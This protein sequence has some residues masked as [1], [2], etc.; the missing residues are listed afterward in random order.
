MQTGKR[1]AIEKTS[2]TAALRVYLAG[3]LFTI[4]ERRCNREL[5]RAIE[6]ELPGTLVLLP[7]DFKIDGRYNDQRAFGAI[8]KGCIDGIDSCHCMVAWLDGPDSDS[9]TCFEVGYAYAKGMPVIGVRTD[10]RL[11]QER[12]VN[13][14]LSRAC[15]A[16]VYRPSFDEDIEGLARDVVRAIRKVAAAK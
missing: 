10:F 7:Q 6:A 12:G 11:N 13:V 14:M 1:K 5:A 3:P 4:H 16:F 9:G 2:P 15:A 8:F